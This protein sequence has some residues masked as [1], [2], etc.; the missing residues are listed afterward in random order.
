MVV[1][2]ASA[3]IAQRSSTLFVR[4]T[5]NA[6]VGN[7]TCSLSS[8]AASK[9]AENAISERRDAMF[10]SSLQIFAAIVK[11][12]WANPP[13]L[14]TAGGVSPQLSSNS[15]TSCTNCNP[16]APAARSTCIGSL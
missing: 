13:F 11:S 12:L 15:S 3:K 4:H 6:G 2:Q 8:P 1:N 5:S 9:P 16:A 14:K 7:Q 10:S